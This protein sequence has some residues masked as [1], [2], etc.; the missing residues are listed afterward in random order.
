MQ[1]ASYELIPVIFTGNTH[2]NHNSI[3]TF[4]KR[5]LPKLK[6]VTNIAQALRD[7]AAQPLLALRLIG[8]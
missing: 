6:E 2:P 7:I 4:L 1:R 8:L 5:F 3:N